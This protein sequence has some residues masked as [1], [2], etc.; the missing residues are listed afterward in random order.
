MM[1]HG[2][3]LQHLSSNHMQRTSMGGSKGFVLQEY[4]GG[5]WGKG[6]WRWLKAKSSSGRSNNATKGVDENVWKVQPRGARGHEATKQA[7]VHRRR[8]KPGRAERPQAGPPR[9]ASLPPSKAPRCPSSSGKSLAQ[10]LV[11]VL[12]LVVQ[13]HLRLSLSLRVCFVQQN[14]S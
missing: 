4:Y 12:E 11:R 10:F 7:W 13:N 6:A 14:T 1:H 9:P 5:M 8:S 3:P 2:M